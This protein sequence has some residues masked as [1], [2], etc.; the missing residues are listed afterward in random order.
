MSQA[1]P[2]SVLQRPQRH[3][4]K[5]HDLWQA[6]EQMAWRID[7]WLIKALRYFPEVD[8]EAIGRTRRQYNQARLQVRERVV[9]LG[10][11]VVRVPFVAGEAASADTT[12]TI[13]ELQ[14]LHHEVVRARDRVEALLFAA[15]RDRDVST[16]NVLLGLQMAHGQLL[17]MIRQL[18]QQGQRLSREQ[19]TAGA[20]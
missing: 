1:Y 20:A 19:L 4:A 12:Q 5:L 7:A 17:A 11:A 2:P 6:E 8:N 14:L 3:S 13:R 9:A 10:R 15:R 16:T 18:F